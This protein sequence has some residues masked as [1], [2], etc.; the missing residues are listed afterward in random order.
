MKY[1][2]DMN[3]KSNNL[4]SFAGLFLQEKVKIT[5]GNKNSELTTK[6]EGKKT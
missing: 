1:I 6:P 4:C 2:N 5:L 3:I